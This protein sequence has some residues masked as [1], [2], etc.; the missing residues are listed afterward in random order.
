MAYYR[1]CPKCGC[2]LDPGERCDCEDE[3]Q[4]QDEFYKDKTRIEKNTGQMIFSFCPGID[5]VHDN[6]AVREHSQEKNRRTVC[7]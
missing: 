3:K 7:G 5:T 6:G 1:I 4:R 2:N